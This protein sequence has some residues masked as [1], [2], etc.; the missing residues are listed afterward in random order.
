M[1]GFIVRVPVGQNYAFLTGEDGADYFFHRSD[2]AEFDELYNRFMRAK[3]EKV[4]LN[5]TFKAK[6][7]DKGK[8]AENV[9]LD[10]DS[11]F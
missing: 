3:E 5:C 4:K 11:P 6:N 10:V 7:S 2:I 9:V 8:R 1:N